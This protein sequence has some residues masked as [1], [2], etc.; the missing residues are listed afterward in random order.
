MNTSALTTIGG[1]LAKA[2]F[3]AGTKIRKFSPELLLV[4][5]IIAGGAAIVTACMSTKKVVED[6]NNDISASYD[7]LDA[8]KKEKEENPEKLDIQELSRKIGKKRFKAWLKLAGKYAKIY[9][10][11]IFLAILSV[12]LVL[13]SHG[14]LKKRYIST[15]LAYKALDEAFKD[16]RERV[17]D[18]VGPDKEL[19]YFNGTHEGGEDTYID[20]NGETH[21][22]K[23]AVK[24]RAK[25]P[26]PYEFD[27]NAKTAPGNWEANSDY[28]FMFLRSVENYLNDLLN[29]RGHVFM[30]EALDA[31]G[32]KRTPAGAVTGWLK[33]A[34]G[35]DY[36][37]LGF[38]E[39]YTDE[40]SDAQDEGYLKNIHLNF[41]VDGPIWENI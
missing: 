13:A 30:N 33:G 39:Y 27:F 31:L 23:I 25:K 7:E 5:G 32:I 11:P 17:K 37:D 1:T 15:T 24:D 36:V 34:G 38:S 26:S 14:V 8:I 18:A 21:T 35:D 6:E 22:D 9:G 20:E 12:C 2:A 40:Y 41:N 16:Y 29:A 4:G 19:H 28:N 10:I 3:K